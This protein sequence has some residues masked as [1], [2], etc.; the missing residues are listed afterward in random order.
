L[1]VGSR[2]ADKYLVNYE[3]WFTNFTWPVEQEQSLTDR[4][5]CQGNKI[6]WLDKKDY[7]IYSTFNQMNVS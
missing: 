4:P 1:S 6:F 3:D 2:Q 5:K 7:C